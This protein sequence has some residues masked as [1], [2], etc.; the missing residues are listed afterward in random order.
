MNLSHMNSEHA[1]LYKLPFDTNSIDSLSCMHVVE[2]IGLGRYGD[3]IDYNGD[4]KAIEQLKK[5]VAPNGNLL[6]V[7]PIGKNKIM[8]NAH[9]IYSYTQVIEYFHNFELI[10]FSLITDD[11]IG[12]CIIEN[13]TQ[14][15]SDQQEY[16]C[17]MFW[18]RKKI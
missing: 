11:D 10:E 5:V 2:H 3:S 9:R 1:D 15:L 14:E 6:F 7:V 4:L 8:Y 17:G 16:G 13:A 18:F 12:G